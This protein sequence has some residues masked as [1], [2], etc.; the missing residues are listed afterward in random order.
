MAKQG[1]EKIGKKKAP[2]S[3]TDGEKKLFGF[4]FDLV[5][6]FTANCL[7]LFRT[8]GI[9]K[10]SKKSIPVQLPFSWGDLGLGRS[11]LAGTNHPEQPEGAGSS[12]TLPMAA[13]SST[14]CPQKSGRKWGKM[15]KCG[16]ERPK[17]VPVGH[18]CFHPSTSYEVLQSNKKTWTQ[19]NTTLPSTDQAWQEAFCCWFTNR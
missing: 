7:S 1:G 17:S 11:G 4:I 5:S 18:K 3:A 12:Q 15:T 6:L 9:P 10:K 2:R 8:S 13:K 16:Q 14:N 19:A